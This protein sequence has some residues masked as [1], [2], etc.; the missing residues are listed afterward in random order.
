MTSTPAF[1]AAS[2]IYG[3]RNISRFAVASHTCRRRWLSATAHSVAAPAATQPTNSNLIKTESKGSS[4]SMFQPEKTFSSLGMGTEICDKLRETGIVHPTHVQVATIPRLLQGLLTQH[5]YAAKVRD[6]MDTFKSMSTMSPTE[7]GSGFEAPE[8]PAE[9]FDDVLVVG[10]E[11]GSGKTLS[12]LLPFVEAINRDPSVRTKAVILQPTRELCAQTL[13]FINSYLPQPIPRTLIL[14]GGLPPDVSDL[15]GVRIYIATPAALRLYMNFSGDH[16]RN[17]KYIV[18]D[19]AD[20]LLSGSFHSEVKEILH[21]A[22]MKPFAERKNGQI[23][24]ENRNRLIFV[25]AT[26]PHWVGERVKSVTN[27]ISSK[28]PSVQH[29]TTESIHRRSTMLKSSWKFVNDDAERYESLLEILS[30]CSDDEKIMVFASTATRVGELVE[31]YG[32]GCLQLHKNMYSKERKEAL[33]AFSSESAPQLE[34]FKDDQ[35]DGVQIEGGK[36]ILFCTDVASRG[37]D[38]G[39]VTRVIEYDFATNVVAHLHRIGRT[40]RAGEKGRSDSLYGNMDEPLVNAI[41]ERDARDENVVVGVFSRNRSFRRKWKKAMGS[42]QKEVG[43]AE[44]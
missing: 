17:D 9:D 14:A 19:E 44:E 2:T 18:V 6:A 41:R 43:E 35:G 11:T 27:W 28:Y 38:L 42:G 3:L 13:R 32:K 16:L 36:K 4:P 37:L 29:I 39:N 22:S 8:A 26:Y 7:D 25:G 24:K 30:S 33:R 23:R 15:A 10:A 1:A 21:Q 40:A 12:Y 20:M 5:E 34:E 31:K